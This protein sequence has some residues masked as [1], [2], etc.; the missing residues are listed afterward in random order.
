M[1]TSA[2]FRLGSAL[3]LF[4]CS[5]LATAQPALKAPNTLG[6]WNVETSPA[7][8]NYA[9]VRF[10]NDQHQLLLETELAD[11]RVDPRCGIRRRMVHQLNA[12]LQRVLR[13]PQSALGSNM[14]SAL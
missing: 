9:I 14:A 2:I 11:L 10:Y 1:K 3:A 12:A 4:F 6:Y 5:M 13:K 8:H 7:T